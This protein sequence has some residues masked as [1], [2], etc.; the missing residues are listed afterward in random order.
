[1]FKDQREE[2]LRIIWDIQDI[3]ERGGHYADIAVL[4]RTNTQPRL[5]M[6]QLLEY[7]VPFRTR[8]NVPNLYE[9]WIAKDL[10]AYIRIAMGS[11]ARSDFLRIIEPAQALYYREFLRRGI[12]L[13]LSLGVVF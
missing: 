10:F 12:P 7:N 5:L 13:H 4:F 3:I 8:D 1:M 6:E 2:N 9:H 11:R